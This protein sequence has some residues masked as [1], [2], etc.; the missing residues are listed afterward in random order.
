MSQGDVEHPMVLKA[1]GEGEG[2][3]G[4]L[5]KGVEFLLAFDRERGG[6]AEDEGLLPCKELGEEAEEVAAAD[7]KGGHTAGVEHCTISD[8]EAPLS[9]MDGGPWGSAVVPSKGID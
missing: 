7:K 4:R 8:S 3:E 5:G 1:V 9:P 2:E 6:E